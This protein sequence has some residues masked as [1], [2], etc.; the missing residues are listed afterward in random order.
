MTSFEKSAIIGYWRCG[1]SCQDI[2][3]IMSIPFHC[4]E[5]II[6]NFKIKQKSIQLWLIRRS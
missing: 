2:S 3:E 6:C 4:V 1:A 5:L